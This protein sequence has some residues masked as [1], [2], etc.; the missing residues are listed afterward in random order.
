M[1]TGGSAPAAPTAAGPVVTFPN[2][3]PEPEPPKPEPR[4]VT[5]AKSR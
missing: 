4:F 2:L 1:P 3:D 5:A